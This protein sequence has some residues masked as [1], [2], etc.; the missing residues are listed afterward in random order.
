[1]AEQPLHGLVGAG[2]VPQV[3]RCGGVAKL[4]SGDPQ[5]G[6]I[7]NSIANLAAEPVCCLWLTRGAWKQVR[8]V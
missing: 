2:M 1:M 7:F 3:D 4:V 8:S 5:T 6:R